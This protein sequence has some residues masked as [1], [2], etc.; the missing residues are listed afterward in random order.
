MRRRFACLRAFSVQP[1]APT[2]NDVRGDLECLEKTDLAL[3]DEMLQGDVDMTVLLGDGAT[4]LPPGIGTLL[5]LC[6]VILS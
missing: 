2:S 5:R 3:R 6:P 1:C 4:R